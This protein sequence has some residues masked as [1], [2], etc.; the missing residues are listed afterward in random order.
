ME[1]ISNRLTADPQWDTL[2]VLSV[3]PNLT[4]DLAERLLPRWVA[5]RT[6]SFIPSCVLLN[7]ETTLPNLPKERMDRELPRRAE[8]R[9]DRVDPILV[10]P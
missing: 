3:L 10:Q 2:N 5:S 4:Q 6:E 1:P 9:V 7:I 8:S